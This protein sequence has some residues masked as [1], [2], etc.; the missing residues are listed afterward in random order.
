MA[1][2]GKFDYAISQSVSSSFQQ[3]DTLEVTF[4]AKGSSGLSNST[5]QKVNLFYSLNSESINLSSFSL[6]IAYGLCGC[7]SLSSQSSE[8]KEF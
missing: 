2:I 6:V 3:G 1:Q 4:Q 8:T 5:D 7:N